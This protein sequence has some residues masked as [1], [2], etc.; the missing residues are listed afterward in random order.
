MSISICVLFCAYFAC[1]S[2][3]E[4]IPDLEHAHE[5]DFDSQLHDLHPLGQTALNNID[6]RSLVHSGQKERRRLALESLPNP[7]VIPINFHIIVPPSSAA[8]AYG[9]WWVPYLTGPLYEVGYER[10]ISQ[11]TVL[12][13]AFMALNED[14]PETGEFA[15][16]VGNFTIRFSLNRIIRTYTT[17]D[18]HSKET[19]RGTAYGGSDSVDGRYILNIWVCLLKAA[20]HPDYILFGSATPPGSA[21]DID[22]FVENMFAFG[23]IDD[24]YQ[25]QGVDADEYKDV[26]P[27]WYPYGKLYGQTPVH[28]LGHWLNLRHIWGDG[29]C[30]YDDFVSDTP[31]DDGANS[32]CPAEA[33]E[34][35]GTH[36]MFMN[37]MD[38]TT[39]KTMFTEGQVERGLDLFTPGGARERMVD[40]YEN[41]TNI[42]Y[43]DY[44]YW[45]QQNEEP[46]CNV[47]HVLIDLDLNEG[48]SSEYKFYL[49]VSHSNNPYTDIITDIVITSESCPSTAYE[50]VDTNL[51]YGTPGDEIYVCYKKESQCVANDAIT[52]MNVFSFDSSYTDAMYNDYDMVLTN[53]NSGTGSADY[54]YIGYKKDD[55]EP[56]RTICYEE[57][58]YGDIKDDTIPIGEDVYYQ[59]IL[60]EHSM[61][62]MTPTES[63]IDHVHFTF[64]SADSG[65]L[66]F[67]DTDMNTMESCQDCNQLM[68]DDVE[69][70]RYFLVVSA[71]MDVSYKLSMEHGIIN[72]GDTVEES[73]GG[74]A[75]L[76]YYRIES[77]TDYEQ[78]YF[79]SCGSDAYVVLL[80][81]YDSEMSVLTEC[82]DCNNHGA[83][84]GYASD[85]T[86]DDWTAGT[87][88]LRVGEDFW[89][90]SSTMGATKIQMF[91]HGVNYFDECGYKYID[92]GVDKTWLEAET[93]CNT[94]FG[95]S[96]ATVRSAE[97]LTCLSALTTESKPWIGL[98]RE[99]EDAAFQFVD[100]TECDTQCND[101][102]QCVCNALWWANKPHYK[103]KY[104]ADCARL[105]PTPSRTTINNDYPCE[106]KLTAVLCNSDTRVPVTDG[107]WIDNILDFSDYSV[108][109]PIYE[110]RKTTI[111]FVL[112]LALI[113]VACNIFVCYWCLCR[114]RCKQKSIK[115]EE[116]SLNHDLDL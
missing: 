35:C 115:Y 44:F 34:S 90:T 77:D 93:Y 85:L 40:Y 110:N 72:C 99:D 21:V 95:T 80:G 70:G 22:G 53:I 30:Q 55:I 62:W 86:V 6:W 25:L 74:Y 57:I 2:F 84:C 61:T 4:E 36:D 112:G 105:Y 11:L 69:P 9:G 31:I 39:C 24:V 41:P 3:G 79:E 28:E 26:W 96:L 114:S 97:D 43:I 32:E 7:I 111:G 106:D 63:S 23:N 66:E 94:Q 100:G 56:D 47:G 50:K 8:A 13:K 65:N 38:Y 88:F 71:S 64:D 82:Y 18:L 75:E 17:V 48:T 58:T 87:Y 92:D 5:C 49:C 60:H 27:A 46:S 51:N 109:T 81:L 73:L 116:V 107:S 101:N 42:E 59:V 104:S 29:G 98:Y 76:H 19:A 54:I 52:S 113:G 45:I 15:D 37:Y 108:R 102:G 83:H 20:Q 68:V 10:I 16:V 33:T 89:G 91:C 103:C 14:I 67:L 78:V 12:N 1:I